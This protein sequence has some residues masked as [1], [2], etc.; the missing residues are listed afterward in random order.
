M[1]LFSSPLYAS[2]LALVWLGLTVNIIRLRWK[3]KISLGDG[4]NDVIMGAVRA[5]GNFCEVVPLVLILLVLAELQGVD[6]VYLHIAGGSLL[7]GRLFHAA[8]LMSANTVNIMRPI[9]MMFGSFLPIILL[10]IL[11]LI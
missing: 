8:A 9:G 10:V 4:N 1:P 3:H 2:L 11:N 5:H 7:I 6:S